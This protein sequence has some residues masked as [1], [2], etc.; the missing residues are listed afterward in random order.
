[1]TRAAG[2]IPHDH[3]FIYSQG[4]P[5]QTWTIIHN[6]NRYPSVTPVN[7]A[8]TKMNAVVDYIDKNR[9]TITFLFPVAGQAYLN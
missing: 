3:S 5:A 4:L 2:I 9:L 1:M 7:S 8:R 6:L